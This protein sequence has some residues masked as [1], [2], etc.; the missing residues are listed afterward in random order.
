[1]TTPRA[2]RTVDGAL[3]VADGS[4]V[5][6]ER[7]PRGLGRLGAVHHVGD[8]VKVQPVQRLVLLLSSELTT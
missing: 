6:V 1:M 2:G 3:S 5:P 4:V 7:L 8:R